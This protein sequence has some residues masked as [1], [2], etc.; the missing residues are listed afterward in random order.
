VGFEP[1]HAILRSVA[2]IIVT[3]IAMAMPTNVPAGYCQKHAP[4][5]AKNA[6]NILDAESIIYSASAFWG[7]GFWD[8]IHYSENIAAASPRS[9]WPLARTFRSVRF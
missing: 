9:F 4:T 3:I 6:A 8:S 7:S 1:L 5:P 2:S